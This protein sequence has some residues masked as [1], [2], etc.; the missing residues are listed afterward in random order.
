MGNFFLWMDNLSVDRIRGI[1]KFLFKSQP[2]GSTESEMQHDLSSVFVYQLFF[3][4]GRYRNPSAYLFLLWNHSGQTELEKASE[5]LIPVSPQPSGTASAAGSGFH[6]WPFGFDSVWR[7]IT[8]TIEWKYRR[9]FTC[10]FTLR[11]KSRTAAWI[12]NAD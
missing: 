10:W 11:E 9:V 5:D 2:N 1:S 3:V 4:L 12:A 7:S 8:A 6:N